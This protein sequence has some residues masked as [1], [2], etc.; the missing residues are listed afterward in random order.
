MNKNQTARTNSIAVFWD[1]ENCAPPRGM[2]GPDIVGNLRSTLQDFGVIRQI[3]AYAELRLIPKDLRIELQRSGVHLIDVPSQEKDAADK[4][5]ISD[6]IMFA[7]DNPSPQTLALISGDRDY[8]YPLAKLRLRGYEVILLIPPVGAHPTLQAQAD[9]IIDWYDLAKGEQLEGPSIPETLATIQFEPLVA[10]LQHLRD[11]GELNP[12]F[13]RVGEHLALKY[14]A[15][16]KKVGVTRLKDYMEEAAKAGLVSWGGNP[17]RYWVTLVL[18]EADAEKPQDMTITDDSRFG[19]LLVILK[20]AQMMGIDEPEMAWIGFQLRSMM[21]AWREQLGCSRLMDYIVEAED[22]ELIEVRH[23]GLQ[24]YVRLKSPDVVES[25]GT[26]E[27]TDLDLLEHA[28]ETLRQDKLLPTEKIVLARMRE[29]SDGWT[30]QRSPFNNTRQL[31]RAAANLRG[32]IIKGEPP[33][34]LVFPAQEEYEGFDPNDCSVDPFSEEQWAA[35]QQF[36]RANPHIKEKGRYFFAKYLQKEGPTQLRELS[37]G[38]LMLLVQL[39]ANR[40]WI[41]FKGLF[42]HVSTDLLDKNEP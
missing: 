31:F 29:L 33:N 37:L 4:M 1:M 35:V 18:P 10:T 3:N 38:E 7:V 15:R 34:R 41:F 19:P 32:I 17:P 8:A 21:P 16:W 39:T 20:K 14:P 25:A 42:L 22:A 5:I 36:L 26:I 40:G 23:E 2:K 30:L 24:H 9:R 13:S 11:L 28:L 6:L 27:Q 12:L